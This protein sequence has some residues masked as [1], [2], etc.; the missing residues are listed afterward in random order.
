MK[1]LS[2]LIAVVVIVL[3][4][5]SVLGNDPRPPGWQPIPPG[6]S[7]VPVTAVSAPGQLA[8]IDAQLP[9]PMFQ[10]SPT[11]TARFILTVPADAIVTFDGKTTSSVG[12]SRSYVVDGLVPGDSYT[13]LFVVSIVRNGVT[14]EYHRRVNYQ[15]G[16][17]IPIE[18]MPLARL[19]PAQ[20]VYQPMS[21]QSCASGFCR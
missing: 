19:P 9:V 16:Q 5:G 4:S 1:N 8:S 15:A 2:R 14:N 13:G 11:G 17:N 20:A 6:A 10:A 12:E 3:H 18:F 21:S 7:T